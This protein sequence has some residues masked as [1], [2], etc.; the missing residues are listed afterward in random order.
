MLLG[1]TEIT[2]NQ[3]LRLKDLCAKI[4]VTLTSTYDS[5][6]SAINDKQKE[7]L[8]IGSVHQFYVSATIYGRIEY[9]IYVEKIETS[10]LLIEIIRSCGFTLDTVSYNKMWIVKFFVCEA[11]EIENDSQ[12]KMIE[13]KKLVDDIFE[14]WA[15]EKKIR[16]RR[17]QLDYNYLPYTAAHN[18]ARRKQISAF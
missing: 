7:F 14:Q 1:C 10:K 3:F 11:E 6:E 2:E 4:G 8:C 5:K 17:F 9:Q 12:Q 18:S 16:D 15:R 13:E